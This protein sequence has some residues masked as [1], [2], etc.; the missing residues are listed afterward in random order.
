MPESRGSWFSTL[1]V[2]PSEFLW[3]SLAKGNNGYFVRI[4]C[5]RVIRIWIF[6]DSR[7]PVTMPLVT[8]PV[9]S[10]RMATNTLLLLQVNDSN[11][12]S[13]LTHWMKLSLKL[14]LAEQTMNIEL[15]PSSVL[16]GKN[17][18]N[19][20][21]MYWHLRN[22]LYLAFYPGPSERK[23]AIGSR[24]MVNVKAWQYIDDLGKYKL[25]F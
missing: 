21:S 5:Y 16:L 8:Y 10:H 17:V 22:H 20:H 2:R 6:V 7:A 9:Y 19:D 12:M 13:N 15:S 25:W 24:R 4:E 3:N 18:D 11:P 23:N 1:I 14:L